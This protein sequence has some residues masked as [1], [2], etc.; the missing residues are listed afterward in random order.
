MYR[1]VHD[2]DYWWRRRKEACMSL[3]YVGVCG[4][5][6]VATTLCVEYIFTQFTE[7]GFFKFDTYR[8]SYNNAV[9]FTMP[10]IVKTETLLCPTTVSRLYV[11]SAAIE[12]RHGKVSHFWQD[13]VQIELLYYVGHIPIVAATIAQLLEISLDEVLEQTRANTTQMYGF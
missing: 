12:R 7:K 1:S 10:R 9:A 13:L 5:Q 2:T 8:F 6:T 4:T 3:R 11:F